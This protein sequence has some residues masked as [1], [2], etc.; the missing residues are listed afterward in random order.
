MDL[1]LSESEGRYYNDLFALCDPE[2]TA[3]AP[4]LKALE[5]FRSSNVNNEILSQVSNKVIT[6]MCNDVQ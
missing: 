1:N 3:R 5:L 4:Y 6:M 2:N